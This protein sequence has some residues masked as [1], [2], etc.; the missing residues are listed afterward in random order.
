MTGPGLAVDVTT[1]TTTPFGSLTGSAIAGDTSDSHWQ[2]EI[3]YT[4]DLCQVGEVIDPCVSEA[5][6]AGTN[7][8]EVSFTTYAIEVAYSCST[9][10]FQTANYEDRVLRALQKNTSRLVEAELWSGTKAQ[11]AGWGNDYL[12][13]STTDLGTGAVVEQFGALESATIAANGGG[14]AFL[15]MPIKLAT[16]LIA[17]SL[18]KREGNLLVTELGSIV[19]AGAGYPEEGSDGDHIHGYGTGPVM[20]WLSSPVV[21]PEQ[22]AQAVDRSVNDTI[23][24]AS[25]FVAHTYGACTVQEAEF[26]VCDEFCE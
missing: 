24:R 1:A 8:S 9:G 11:A 5:A 21:T 17:K 20:L 3:R 7:P 12:T 26:S 10:G 25:R 16:V 4:P 14:R 18:V 15:H 6:T 2:Q 19:V 23:F 22:V 13:Q